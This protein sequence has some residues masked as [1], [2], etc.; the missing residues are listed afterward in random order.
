MICR[1]GGIKKHESGK[2]KILDNTTEFEI[3][4]SVATSFEAKIKRPDK[5][6]NI[7][8]G[9]VSSPSEAEPARQNEPRERDYVRVDQRKPAHKSKSRNDKPYQDDEA[10]HTGKP[11]RNAVF[12]RDG[13][14][15]PGDGTFKKKKAK[16]K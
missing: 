3:L 12:Q 5:E 15:K 1:R 4:A 9:P 10:R 16:H 7:R 11:K 2:I 8:I 6:D 13:A 14:S